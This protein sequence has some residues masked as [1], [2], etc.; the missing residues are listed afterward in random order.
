MDSRVGVQRTEA[1]QV[2]ALPVAVDRT[3]TEAEAAVKV[4]NVAVGN[5]LTICGGSGG[6]ATFEK[7]L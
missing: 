7:F 3:A 6:C 2:A 5:D 4:A 1:I